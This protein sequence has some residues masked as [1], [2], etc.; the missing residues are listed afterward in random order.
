MTTKEIAVRSIAQLPDDATWEDIAER[1][2]FLAA[3]DK[4]LEDI[5]EGKL[6]PHEDVK[7]SLE[8]WLST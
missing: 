8:E 6:I 5:R 4:G 1:V 2:R 7:A 3:I